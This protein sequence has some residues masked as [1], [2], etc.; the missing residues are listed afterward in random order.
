MRQRKYFNKLNI[1]GPSPKPIVGNLL[2][3]INKGITKNDEELIEKYGKIVG[4]HEGATPV[5]LC[6]DLDMIKHI[7]IK[8]FSYF[9]NRRVY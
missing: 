6:T 1:P 7:M 4:Y 9:V 2:D 3:L 8:D 5:I